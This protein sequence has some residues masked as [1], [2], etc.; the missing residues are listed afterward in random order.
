MTEKPQRRDPYGGFPA[1]VARVSG[2]DER[3]PGQRPHTPEPP[4]TPKRWYEQRAPIWV[5]VGLA[6]FCGASAAY[7]LAAA[8]D[9]AGFPR[10][11][12]GGGWAL[13]S[14]WWLA[15]AIGKRRVARR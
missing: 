8:D 3:P 9:P 1:F 2:N 11:F 10:Y 12:I 6:L 14:I 7:W 5:C 15:V 4:R 13:V